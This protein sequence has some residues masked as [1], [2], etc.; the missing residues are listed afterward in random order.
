MVLNT[1]LSRAV[2]LLSQIILG[3][4]LSP[5]DFGVYALALSIANVVTVIRNGG[6]SQVLIQRGSH[7]AQ[8][9]SPVTQ[10]SLV[11]NVVALVILVGVA[12]AITA[13]SK[14]PGAAMLAVAIGLSFPLGT[15][16]NVFRSELSVLGRFK[17][18][19]LLNTLSTG[20]WQVEVIALAALG[21]GAYSFAIPM[22]VQS[23]VDTLLGWYY[24]RTWP[25]SR[26]L[27]DWGQFVELFRETRW[28]MLGAAMYALGNTGHYFAAGLFTDAATVGIFFFGFQ[29]AN[30]VFAV[31]NNAIETVLPPML[32]HLNLDRTRQS[33]ALMNMF[34]M[35]MIVSLPLTGALIVG[36]YTGVHV[37]W[38]GRWD[39]SAK[40]ISIM[41]C[42]IPSWIV[43]AVVRATQEARGL[44]L[45]RLY[46]LTVYGVGTVVAVGA[47][48][49]TG[50][51]D[52][53]SG[54]LTAFYMLFG[55]IM[56]VPLRSMADAPFGDILGALL[57]PL[58]VTAVCVLV[59]LWS[60]RLLPA[61]TSAVFGGL[62]QTAIYSVF[63][64][65]ANYLIFRNAWR[66]AAG[67]LSG[68]AV[69]SQ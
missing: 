33:K 40:V 18:L 50:R 27:L 52:A 65:A 62:V 13:S 51:V 66:A 43:I 31:I 36:A 16:A 68:R 17:E 61:A 8:I 32:A 37:L 22:I 5:S 53:M 7:Y 4:L 25:M 38:N 41:A 55:M 10:Y 58:A 29:L 67:F 35:L 20:M 3:F 26:P 1:M 44:W 11:F 28:I 14:T 46:L 39:S 63:A 34:A 9:L 30:T 47:A 60:T 64:L 15:F 42:S 49:T 69:P 2:V 21:F 48:A 59:A 54:A 56:L 6:T 19:A 12:P 57:P 45:S 23:L 24:V